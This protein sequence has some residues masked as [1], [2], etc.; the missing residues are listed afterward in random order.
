MSAPLDG[1]RVIDFT[2]V[3]ARPH[4]T[5]TLRDLGAEVIK[6]EPPS[7]DLGR[8]GLPHIDGMGLYYVQ[9]NAGER[10]LSIDLNWPE[11]REIVTEMCR[12]ADIIVENFRPGTLDRFR[13]GYEDIRA[14]NPRVIYASLSGYGQATSRRNRPAFA[15]TV[16]GETGLTAIVQEHFG[17]ALAEPRNDACSHADV[18]TGLQGVIGILAALHAREAAGEG[19]FVDV[20]MAATMLAVNERAGALLSGIDTDGEPIGLSANES[21]IYD[22]GDGRKITIASSPI[23]SPMFVRYCAMMRRNELLR[24]P[25]YATARLRK[26]N[27]DSFLVEVRAWIMTFSDLDELQAQASESGLALGEIRTIKEFSE[28]EW[29]KE[30]GAI[31]QIDNRA[32]G[33]TPMP[34]NPWIF[35][36]SKLPPPGAPSFQGE[37][38]AE[39]LAGF[40][41]SPEQVEDL[42]RRKILVSRRSPFDVVD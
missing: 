37:N 12:S 26:E 36:G 30:W 2:R 17:K 28:G 14:I 13:L 22:L 34:G 11:A 33:T 15:P 27:I 16:H 5:K 10:N 19:Q 39:I 20:S 29:V 42:R 6:I 32:G 40:N 35:S 7:G 8:M 41:V 31:I 1:V 3:L 4:C 38:N 25:R 21:H 18:Y 9:Q 24:D 23:Y